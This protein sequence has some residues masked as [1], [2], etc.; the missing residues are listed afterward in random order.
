V[1]VQYVLGDDVAAAVNLAKSSDVAIVCVGNNPNQDNG[2][3]KIS[4]P[5]KEGRLDR[6][7][8]TLDERR[9]Y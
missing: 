3:K 7:T 5:A 1:K 4:S 6:K 9:T 8:I 2:W